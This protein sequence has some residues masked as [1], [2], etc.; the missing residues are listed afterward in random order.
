MSDLDTLESLSPT[1]QRRSPV[2]KLLPEILSAIFMLL[3]SIDKPTRDEDDSGVKNSLGWLTVTQVCQHWRNAALEDATLWASNIIAPFPF[4]DRWAAI[5][6]SRAQYAPLAIGSPAVPWYDMT[7]PTSSE[8]AF[9]SNNSARIRILEIDRITTDEVPAFC[10]A[11]PLLHTLH[12]TA[13]LG[14]PILPAGFLGGAAGAPA[15]RHLSVWP[16]LP[17]SSPLLKHLISLDI[18][19]HGITLN[20]T[21]LDEMLDA[22]G[23]M[24]ALQ[25]LKLWFQ[26]E[27]SGV[28]GTASEHVVTLAALRHLNVFRASVVDARLLLARLEL[29]PDT[30]VTCDFLSGNDPME[31]EALGQTLR[32]SSARAAAFSRIDIQEIYE[33]DG[34]CLTVAAWRRGHTEGMPALALQLGSLDGTYNRI[35]LP[36]LK[37]IASEHLEELHVTGDDILMQWPPGLQLGRLRSLSVSGS[38]AKSFYLSMPSTVSRLAIS[39]ADLMGKDEKLNGELD[40]TEA[41]LGAML[42]RW[43]ADRAKAGHALDVLD[44]RR[45]HTDE[46]FVRKVQDAVTGIVVR[47]RTEGDDADDMSEEEDFDSWL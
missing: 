16:P 7:P 2:A 43:L 28:P 39:G 9:I 25:R 20:D 34:V 32:A 18:T 47:W 4:G 14:G 1:M 5:F 33:Q 37:G 22:L 38:M 29:P 10:H 11:M 13:R 3:S 42:P 46:A 12:L 27:L 35:G 21:M 17:W 30:R 44:V 31:I 8:L 41:A 24:R 23:Q 19:A 40:W 15:L 36:A 26:L 6:F 45:C